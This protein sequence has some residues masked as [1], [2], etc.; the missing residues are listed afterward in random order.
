MKRVLVIGIGAGSPD[1][2]TMQA[3]DAL[4]Q[5][6]VF[7][8]LDKGE[9]KDELVRVRKE[10]CERYIREPSYR[11]VEVDDP[12]RDR[13]PSNYET[14]VAAWRGKRTALYKSL[15]E[16]ELKDGECGAFLVWGDPSLYDGTIGMLQQILAEGSIIFDYEVIPGISS[17]QVL[18]AQ[19]KIPL[20]RVGQGLLITTG[21]RLSK[22]LPDDLD[23]FVVMLETQSAFG[24]A[25][26]DIDIY[27]GAY[28]GMDDEMLVSG[29]LSERA[30]EIVRLRQQQKARKGWI[31]DTC[32]LRRN[33][34][35]S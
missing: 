18:A 29:K 4:N 20:N 16:D 19:H 33:R 17:I 2:V 25:G 22:G 14:E 35:T 6:D 8:L 5:V 23:D 24:A 21:R 12:A 27:W 26:D 1:H 34:R 11:M 7:F 28:L 13:A 32:L 9:E 15:I 31:M 10:I 3:V 30:D